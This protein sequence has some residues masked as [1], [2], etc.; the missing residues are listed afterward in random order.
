MTLVAGIVAALVREARSEQP[1]LRT[2]GVHLLLV[3]IL[4]WTAYSA[5]F[6]GTLTVKDPFFA[7]LDYLGIV[8]FALFWVAPAAFP[9]P[10]ERRILLTTL[11]GVGLYL[12][13]TAFFETIGPSALVFPRYI[14]DP[15]VG[16]HWG[17]ARGP[18]V[19]AAGKRALAVRVRGRRG[20]R[21]PAV[22]AQVASRSPRCVS[23]RHGRRVLRHAPDLGGRHRRHAGGDGV[24]TGGCAPG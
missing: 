2:R 21:D 7:L 3:A 6:A 19:E 14:M 22:A 18:F 8:P 23:V 24:A 9:G 16:I 17:R 5:L 10:R 1:R 20:G 13:A 11:V 4:A 12:G 15:S